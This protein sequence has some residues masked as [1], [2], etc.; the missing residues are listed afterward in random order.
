MSW[1]LHPTPSTVHRCLSRS[2]RLNHSCRCSTTLLCNDWSC[3]PNS[4]MLL[5]CQLA[6][7]HWLRNSS[8][9][10][11]WPGSCLQVYASRQ[12]YVNVPVSSPH[13]TNPKCHYGREEGVIAAIFEL[14]TGMSHYHF[15]FGKSHSFLTMVD[16]VTGH[17]VVVFILGGVGAKEFWSQSGLRAAAP[18][19]KQSTETSI[20]P[21]SSFLHSRVC[22]VGG[23]WGMVWVSGRHMRWWL[24][25]TYTDNDVVCN[26][27]HKIT[28]PVE[29]VVSG[30][31]TDGNLPEMTYLLIL[32]PACDVSQLHYLIET[33]SVEWFYMILLFFQGQKKDTNLVSFSGPL[34]N[35]TSALPLTRPTS[36]TIVYFAPLCTIPQLC[37]YDPSHWERGDNLGYL[38]NIMNLPLVR[39]PDHDSTVG[40]VSPW[41]LPRPPRRVVYQIIK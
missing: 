19:A 7:L 20:Q 11:Q 18:E 12:P 10:H 3:T 36:C 28:A 23:A 17:F 40:T 5:C 32:A 21:A 27:Q 31:S 25:L 35:T 22:Y 4:D 15:K 9:S 24:D 37:A 39:P 16:C 14:L 38:V 41:C 6:W 13:T 34:K 30:C 29:H 26:T 2:C 1:L 33:I 8:A